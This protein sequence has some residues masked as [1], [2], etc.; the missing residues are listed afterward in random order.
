MSRAAPPTIKGLIGPLADP[1]SG[2]SLWLLAVPCGEGDPLTGLDL[3]FT[4]RQQAAEKR[5]ATV[6]WGRLPPTRLRGRRGAALGGWQSEPLE[7]WG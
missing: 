4:V 5:G 1:P 7:P 3:S 6:R 2:W